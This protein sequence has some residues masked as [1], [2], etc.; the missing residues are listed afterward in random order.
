MIVESLAKEERRYAKRLA[1]SVKVKVYR[2]D[3]KRHNILRA[4]FLEAKDMTQKGFFVKIQKPFPLNTKLKIS[5]TLPNGKDHVLLEGK[6]AWIANQSQVGYYPGM[7]VAITK[8]K[9]G[10]SK[11]IKGFLKDKF[12]NYR[13]ALELKEMYHQL[14]DMG[15]RLY[16]MEQSHLHALHFRKVIDRAIKD[17]DNIAHILDREVWEVKRL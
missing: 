11:R 17:I 13:Q 14:K 10:D 5:L 12:H 9:I 6:V 1:V 3:K 16:D 7:G 15:G 4:Y 8:I 2:L